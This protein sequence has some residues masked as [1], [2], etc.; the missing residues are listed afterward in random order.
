MPTGCGLG[1]V[2]G[3]SGASRGR[4]KKSLL[5]QDQSRARLDVVSGRQSSIEWALRANRSPLLGS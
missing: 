2:H 1:R 3:L 5:S 4:G